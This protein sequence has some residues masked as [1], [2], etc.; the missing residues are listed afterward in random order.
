MPLFFA[1]PKERRAKPQPSVLHID[2]GPMQNRTS[3]VR[4]AAWLVLLG[5]LTACTPEV[6]ITLEPGIVARLDSTSI[7]TVELRDFVVQMPQHLRLQGQGEPVRQR[8]LRSLLGKHL[9]LLEARERGLDTAQVVLSQVMPQWRQHLIDTFRRVALAPN[10][11]ISQEEIA[12]YFAASGL[13]RKRQLAGILVD[14]D[15]TAKEIYRRLQEGED[16]ARLATEYTIDQRSA[17]TLR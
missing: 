6:E 11:Q 2:I 17:S 4:R 13:D 8:Y 14:R 3:R 9:L 1:R 15:S 12:A 16:F 7:S 10:V 5:T